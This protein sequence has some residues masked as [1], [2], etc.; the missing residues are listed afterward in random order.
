M[1]KVFDQSL[2]IAQL[3]E[4]RADALRE[5]MRHSSALA[6]AQPIVPVAQRR[7]AILPGDEAPVASPEPA[8]AEPTPA[9]AIPTQGIAVLGGFLFL[10]DAWAIQTLNFFGPGQ[11]SDGIYWGSAL[12]AFSALSLGWAKLSGLRAPSAM[13]ALALVP[14]A[15]LLISTIATDTL[16]PPALIPMG[17]AGLVAAT[18]LL[19]RRSLSL[20]SLSRGL[21]SWAE[22]GTV[23]ATTQVAALSIVLSPWAN[24]LDYW[25]WLGWLQ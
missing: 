2:A 25:V 3:L 14:R 4:A 10:L 12:L 5:A 23:L 16:A 13:G 24:T 1:A 9:P 15:L 21:P 19:S 17:I 11:V 20:H 22:A 7:P 8:F 18:A 6:P